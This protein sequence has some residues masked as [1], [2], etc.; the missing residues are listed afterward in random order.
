MEDYLNKYELE[1]SRQVC[2]TPL[3]RYR[4]PI[5][6]VIFPKYIE[7]KIYRIGE[8]RTF[9]TRKNVLKDDSGF[10]EIEAELV[11]T[12]STT[13]VWVELNQWG[14]NVD[15][16]DVRNILIALDEKT[17][18]S[19]IDSTKG[20]LELEREYFGEIPD[21]DNTGKLI[22]LI[23]DIRDGYESGESKTFVAGYFDWADQLPAGHPQASGNSA[24]IIYIDSDPADPSSHVVMSTVSHELQHL[25]HYNYDE[26]EEVWLNEG[27]SEY[28][29]YLTGYP[30]RSFHHFLMKTDRSLKAWDNRIEDYSRVAL[31]TTYLV[32]QFGEKFLA[33]LVQNRSNG[34]SSIE[35]TLW[36]FGIQLSFRTLFRNWIIANY[37]NNSTIS[38]G[39][40][41]YSGL[42]IPKVNPR[43][44]H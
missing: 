39:E 5:Y 33:S 29:S 17:P 28:A 1:K 7:K 32:S 11:D 26:N 36:L 30:Y 3:I 24:D 23:L 18:S 14:L 40:F 38:S 15:S 6:P 42:R 31:F 35:E 37:L 4:E 41:G 13:D 9:Y 44:R 2:A 43:F 19:S 21:V 25:I 16:S 20:I 10:I 12:S 8:R 22:V 27:L 34:I